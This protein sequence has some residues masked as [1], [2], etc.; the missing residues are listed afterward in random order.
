MSR[1]GKL[2]IK[3]PSS[4]ETSFTSDTAILEVKGKYGTLQS[5]IPDVLGIEEKDDTLLVI[6]KNQARTTRA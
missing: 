2:P 6:L 4:I 5:Q 3:I 1:I